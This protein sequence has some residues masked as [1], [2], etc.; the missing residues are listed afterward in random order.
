MSSY[1][2]YVLGLIPAALVGVTALLSLVGLSWH[3]AVPVGAT[4]ALG[5]MAHAMF[6]NGPRSDA[7]E[8]ALNAGSLTSE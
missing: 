3:A 4:I 7:G 6:I 1:Y 8:S 2:D 5:L